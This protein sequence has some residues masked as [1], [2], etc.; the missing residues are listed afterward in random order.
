VLAIGT[1]AYAGPPEPHGS[2]PEARASA[3][4]GSTSFDFSFTYDECEYG[5]L[6]GKTVAEL[7]AAGM[8]ISN[9]VPADL[10]PVPAGSQRATADDC[11]ADDTSLIN[12]WSA[13][14]PEE[15]ELDDETRESLLAARS[16]LRRRLSA[17]QRGS[18]DRRP[19]KPTSVP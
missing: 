4:D 12:E 14:Q 9:R 11:A 8:E 17:D 15:P 16:A 10:V 18:G 5:S 19:T 1:S 7:R 6:V 2:S 3:S 13:E